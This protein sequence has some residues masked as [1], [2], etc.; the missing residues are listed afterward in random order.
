MGWVIQDYPRRA[1][2]HAWR[3]DRWLPGR[4]TLRAQEELGIVLLNNLHGAQMNLAVSNTLVDQSP[5]PG[6][7]DWNGYLPEGALPWRPRRKWNAV[8]ANAGQQSSM[9]ETKRSHVNWSSLSRRVFHDAAYGTARVDAGGR[10]ARA[11][12]EHIHACP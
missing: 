3:R 6:Y 12:L 8:E 10:Q 1:A 7:R 2:A 5:R 11:A 9:M 4:F